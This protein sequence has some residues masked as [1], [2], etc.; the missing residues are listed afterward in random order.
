MQPSRW[1]RIVCKAQL[2]PADNDWIRFVSAGG[3]TIFSGDFDFDSP[4]NTYVSTQNRTVELTIQNFDND[5]VQLLAF[6]IQEELN[7]LI[8]VTELSNTSLSSA[9]S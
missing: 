7:V 6:Q 5:N 3:F 9:A 8:E 2:R 1:Y 4:N